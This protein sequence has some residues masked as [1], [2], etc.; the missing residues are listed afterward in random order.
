MDLDP[1]DP[2]TGPAV[3]PRLCTFAKCG[4]EDIGLRWHGALPWARFV[5]QGSLLEAS[6]PRVLQQWGAVVRDL[7]GAAQLPVPRHSLELGAEGEFAL[8]IRFA[9]DTDPVAL[10]Q[11]WGCDVPHLCREGPGCLDW[12]RFAEARSAA[13]REAPPPTEGASCA[14]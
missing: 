4:P 10:E 7:V 2:E 5:M 3:F 8:V 12:G 1:T 6:R 11:V 9:A 14:E 13:N